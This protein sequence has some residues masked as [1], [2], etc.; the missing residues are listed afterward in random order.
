[1]QSL[2]P[3]H[4]SIN[5]VEERLLIYVHISRKYLCSYFYKL[6]GTMCMQEPCRKYGSV[7][8][9]Q[10]RGMFSDHVLSLL[11]VKKYRIQ[12]RY[13]DVHFYISGSQSYTSRVCSKLRGHWPQTPLSAEL[14]DSLIDLYSDVRSS[15]KCSQI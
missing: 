4:I 9:G 10:C 6:Q 3:T 1:M 13:V 7:K 11:A 12:C 14:N 8:T 15:F 2:R 5:D